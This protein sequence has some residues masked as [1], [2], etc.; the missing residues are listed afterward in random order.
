MTRAKKVTPATF[1]SA[2][3]RKKPPETVE[4][5]AAQVPEAAHTSF[6]QLRAT[7]QA[8]VPE[9]A[10]EIISY[11]IP[12]IEYN[13]ILVWFAAFSKHCSL[14]PTAAVIDAFREELTGYRTFKGTIHFPLDQPLP[15]ALIKRIV[16]AR[17]K[18]QQRRG[19]HH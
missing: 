12:A 15:T 3:K 19:H 11:R 7:I 17:L 10:R 13:G 8:A 5:Y 6:A 9:D 16:R 4:D 14:F 1:S 18:G 2:T